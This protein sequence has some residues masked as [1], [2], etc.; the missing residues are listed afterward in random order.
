MLTGLKNWRPTFELPSPI[1][2]RNGLQESLSSYLYRLKSATNTSLPLLIDE[3]RLSYPHLQKR[4]FIYCLSDSNKIPFNVS[5]SGQQ[6]HYIAAV[7]ETIAPQ[8]RWKRHTLHPSKE[9]TDFSSPLKLTRKSGWCKKCLENQV[10]NGSIVYWPLLWQINGYDHCHIHNTAL[11]FHCGT[12]GE[13]KSD[14]DTGLPL[15][16]CSYCKTKLNRSGITPQPTQ[17]EIWHNLKP[18]IIGERLTRF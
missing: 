11:S 9:E 8:T 3:L 10:S 5:G 18:Q 16:S 6:A 17:L 12:C 13:P 14:F 1:Y 2:N 7:L 15:N 4:E